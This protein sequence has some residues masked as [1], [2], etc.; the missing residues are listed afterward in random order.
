[1]I[2]KI[3]KDFIP[4]LRKLKIPE[5]KLEFEHPLE[6]SHGDYATNIAMRVK[7]KGFSSPVQLA[8]EIVNTWRRM[9]L[10]PWLS[11]VSVA[12][13]GFINIKLTTQTLSSQVAK[14]LK[15]KESYGRGKAKKEKIMVEFAHPNTHKLFHIGHLRNIILG[16][17]ISRLLEFK[18]REVVRANY[19]GD[20]GLHIAKV[21]WGLKGIRRRIP[22]SLKAKIELLADCYVRG[23]KAYER[24][25]RSRKQIEDLNQ[26][27]YAKDP[28]IL[29][30]WEKTKKWSLDYF[31]Q[32]Y[33]R[34]NIFFD[35]FYFESEVAEKGKKMVLEGLKKG[36]FEK[37]EG[38]IIFPGERYGLHNRVFITQKG[39]ATYEAK[40]LALADLQFSE[41][42]P[43]KIIHIVGPEQ[44]GYFEVLFK[45]LERVL[46]KTKNKEKHLLYGWVRLRE[47]K[48]A[49]REGSVVEAGWLLDQVKEEI[50]KILK[51]QRSYKKKEKE[52]IA[53][54]VAV[55]AVKYS[56]LKYSVGRD[57]V[58]DIE[59]SVNLEGD[60][61]C[62][63]LYTYA[64]SRSVLR[65]AG[66]STNTLLTSKK[67]W[68]F[69][70]S[71]EISL[72]RTLYRF[73]EVVF[74]ASQIFNPGLLCSFLFDLAQKYNL[75]YNRLSILKPLPDVSDNQLA[76]QSAKVV[77]QSRLALT[78]ACAQI[79]KNG[80]ELLGIEALE[81]M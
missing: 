9:G 13:P 10:P 50:L 7:K 73:P 2:E 64:R 8:Q 66:V 45:A 49:S 34:L 16:E 65:K 18:G 74:E 61:G 28:E 48:M 46:P 69:R 79:I 6:A 4:V 39:L 31:D 43:D 53:E 80:L 23:N 41:F 56:L 30:L 33:K 22:R 35:R 1:M 72:L 26:K 58:F 71:E 25:E 17:A 32:I 20:V 29:E 21:L 60:S 68:Q 59:E 27:L 14:V 78:A 15:E 11:S 63:L 62:Y 47:G 24:T 75:F 54:T 55:A 42:S 19:Q 67:S 44:K 77:R 12:K 37:S 36:I 5:D 52:K 70:E 40:D 57:I 51:N 76:S 3:E 38:A 81:R